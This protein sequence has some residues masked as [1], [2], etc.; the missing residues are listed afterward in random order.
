MRI[1]LRKLGLDSNEIEAIT[2]GRGANSRLLILKGLQEP[3]ERGRVS[4]ITGIDWKEV[5]REIGFLMNHGFVRKLEYP[6]SRQV[7]ALS[8]KGQ[9]TLLLLSTIVTHDSASGEE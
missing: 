9:A 7:F 6:G 5:N 8:G 3:S 4:S 1:G 2:T